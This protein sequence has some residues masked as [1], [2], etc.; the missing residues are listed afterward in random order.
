VDSVPGKG[1]TFD[2]YLPKI[3]NESDIK[4]D[5][6]TQPTK[7]RERILIID[8]EASVVNAVKPGLERLGYEIVAKTSSI[9]A[10]ELFHK[11]YKKIDM[12]ITDHTMPEMTGFALAKEIKIIQPDIPII[13]CTGHGDIVDK[14]KAEE[15]GVR[16]II[17][18]P[19]ILYEMVAVIRQ[20]FDNNS[21]RECMDG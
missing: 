13:L 3:V 7:G 20:A 4:S 5:K 12:V 10:I 17:S 1:S 14:E 8:D 19:V 15:A 21:L 9:E 2:I 11:D 16:D 18:K 6:G